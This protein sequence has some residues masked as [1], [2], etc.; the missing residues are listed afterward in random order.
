MPYAKKNHLN[1]NLSDWISGDEVNIKA[2][3]LVVLTVCAVN[4]LNIQRTPGTEI[5]KQR[6]GPTAQS[7][8][9]C[10]EHEWYDAGNV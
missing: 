6:K 9:G 7:L 5:I 4:H 2:D 3:G 10:S 1:T 8:C